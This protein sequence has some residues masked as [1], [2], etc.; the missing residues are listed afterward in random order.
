MELIQFFFI[1]Y[2]VIEKH[3]IVSSKG[4]FSNMGIVSKNI[5]GDAHQET[6]IGSCQA[7]IFHFFPTKHDN[8]LW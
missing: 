4:S 1:F 7:Y 5:L 8:V 2:F 6:P 3:F